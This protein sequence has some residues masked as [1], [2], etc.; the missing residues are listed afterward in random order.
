MLNSRSYP[1]H[2]SML[3]FAPK[4]AE[5]ISGCRQGY[6]SAKAAYWTLGNFFYQGLQAKQK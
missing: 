3:T 2:F 4:G 1:K 5:H 6:V